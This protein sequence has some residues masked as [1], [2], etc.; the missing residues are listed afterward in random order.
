M[1]K[2]KLL[3]QLREAIRVRHYSI[4][5]EQAYV[6]WVRRF[7][8]FHNK[9]HPETMGAQE[10][11]VFLTFLAKDKNVAASIQNQALCV[12]L[13]LYRH[14]LDMELE[15]LK[16]V[17]RAKKPQQLPVVLTRDKVRLIFTEVT[18]LNGLITR[19]AYV[20][21]RVL[22]V[23]FNY[24]QITVRNGK[25]GKDRPTPGVWPKA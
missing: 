1:S 20:R 10:V 14:V 17:V 2:P 15:W 16:D 9:L 13:F 21:L 7:I 3:D 6:H 24:H 25:G 11:S 12:I 4:R 22:N 18:G 19:L 23:D 8:L 5:T